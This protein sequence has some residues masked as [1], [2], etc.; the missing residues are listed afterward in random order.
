MAD[1]MEDGREIL[2]ITLATPILINAEKV[3]ERYCVDAIC[4]GIKPADFKTYVNVLILEGMISET[5]RLYLRDNNTREAQNARGC[6]IDQTQ[7]D[8]GQNP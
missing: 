3:H 1:E 8:Q 7:D 4:R 5:K 6:D 2:D